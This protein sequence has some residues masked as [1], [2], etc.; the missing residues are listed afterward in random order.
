MSKSTT[1]SQLKIA[2][3]G[4]GLMGWPMA[5][6]LLAAGFSLT[7]W[8]KT[9]ANAN[10]LEPLG[11]VLAASA[12]QAVKHADITISMLE[13]GPVTR[14][15]LE[16]STDASGVLEA[17]A[18]GSLWIDMCSCQPAEARY[19]AM[20]LALRGIEALDAPVSGGTVG[21]ENASLAIM[22]GGSVQ[23]FERAAPVLTA[24]G[25]ATHVG[26]AGAG[27][28]CKLANQLVVGV[29]IGAVA[30]ALL[31]VQHGGGDPE[32]FREAIADGFADGK[33]MQIHGQRMLNGDFAKRGAMAVQLKDM[34]NIAAQAALSG[35]ELPIS[36][37]LQ[38]LYDSACAD[39]RV[40]QLDH[41]ALYLALQAHAKP[42]VEPLLGER[43]PGAA[44]LIE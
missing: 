20:R 29:T 19:N 18:A 1:D 7:A 12:A 16:G 28:L 40:A 33:I 39:P 15:V 23:A 38:S 41:S 22:V 31:L 25:R 6:C 26:E 2:M 34:N 9:A 10:R 14:G 13:N 44:P 36:G 35:I 27:Q 42:A 43:P 32:K 37:L 24:M 11:A 17:L 3:L 5:Q 4:I 30:E 8:S 21:A